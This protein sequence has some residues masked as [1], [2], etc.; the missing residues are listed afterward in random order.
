MHTKASFSLVLAA[1]PPGLGT[2]VRR[3]RKQVPTP[4]RGARPGERR[5]HWMPPGSTPGCGESA[6][7]PGSSAG[8]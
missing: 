5:K 8:W 2:A 1:V 6:P 3:S 4:R 7:R